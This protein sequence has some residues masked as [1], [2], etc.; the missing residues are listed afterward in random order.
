MPYSAGRC[1]LPILDDGREFVM[2]RCHSAPK[3]LQLLLDQEI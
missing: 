3:N 1:A 2:A